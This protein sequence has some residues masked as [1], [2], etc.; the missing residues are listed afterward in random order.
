MAVCGFFAGSSRAGCVVGNTSACQALEDDLAREFSC[1]GEAECH[2]L[3]NAFLE[4][5]APTDLLDAESSLLKEMKNVAQTVCWAGKTWC[6]SLKLFLLRNRSARL[7]FPLNSVNASF[8][9][10]TELMRE[11]DER[12]GEAWAIANCEPDGCPPLNRTCESLLTSSKERLAILKLRMF[13]SLRKTAN[14]LKLLSTSCRLQGSTFCVGFLEVKEQSVKNGTLGFWP[15]QLDS[16]DTDIFYSQK[17]A[18]RPCR[19][20]LACFDELMSSVLAQDGE[21]DSFVGALQ[22]SLRLLRDPRTNSSLWRQ[23]LLLSRSRVDSCSSFVR[24]SSV[25]AT[26]F[27]CPAWIAPR[28]SLRDWLDLNLYDAYCTDANSKEAMEQLLNCW[29]DCVLK[30]DLV[31]FADDSV[32]ERN[33]LARAFLKLVLVSCSTHSCVEVCSGLLQSLFVDVDQNFRMAMEYDVPSLIWSVLGIVMQALLVICCLTAFV[34]IACVWKVGFAARAFL[35]ILAMVFISCCCRLAWWVLTLQSNFFLDPLARESVEVPLELI[36]TFGIFVITVVL[37]FNWV[38]ALV[39]V[40]GVVLSPR[41][42]RGC[43]LLICLSVGSFFVFMIV[44][45]YVTVFSRYH[46]ALLTNPSDHVLRR[47][48]VNYG[49]VVLHLLSIVLCFALLIL[50]VVGFFIFRKRGRSQ[51]EIAAILRLA[52]VA[53][54]LSTAQVFKMVDFV[55][56]S[57]ELLG[58]GVWFIPEWFQYFVVRCV[59]ECLQMASVLYVVVVASRSKMSGRVGLLEVELEEMKSALL[60]NPPPQYTV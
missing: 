37:T 51:R 20:D 22:N 29:T 55:M 49:Y 11:L 39:D 27:N 18:K 24:L 21:K 9:S 36:P 31:V 2:L 47:L 57:R 59:A 56:R 35:V 16:D 32:R 41:L 43:L 42:E 34:L 3:M 13:Y 58:D 23:A 12:C 6:P 1:S 28:A 26:T 54:L 5:V 8:R 30:R 50:S 52:I 45:G 7:P 17:L 14:S 4:S 53:M 15:K 44:S 60:S 19:S 10:E 33:R 25:H 40:H 38:V 46:R 48:L